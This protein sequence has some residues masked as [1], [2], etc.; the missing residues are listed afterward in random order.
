MAAG[1]SSAAAQLAGPFIITTLDELN[2]QLLPMRAVRDM[3]AAECGSIWKVSV[4]G[5]P[6]IP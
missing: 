5:R 3:S 6:D 1:S 2:H 4:L